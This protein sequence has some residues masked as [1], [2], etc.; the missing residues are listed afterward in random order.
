[1]ATTC[2]LAPPARR[3]PV[4]S[5]ATRQPGARPAST[6][7]FRHQRSRA[8]RLRSVP[9]LS[10]RFALALG[11]L[12]AGTVTSCG[13]SPHANSSGPITARRVSHGLRLTLMLPK[14]SYPRNALIGATVKVQNVSHHMISAPGTSC[15]QTE[16]F[17]EDI[18][19]HGRILYPDG[20]SW[21]NLI[22]PCGAATEDTFMGPGF[23]RSLGPV[24][25]IARSSTLRAV[26]DIRESG[27]SQTSNTPAFSP[28]IRLH[29]GP[30]SAPKIALR[31]QAR[32]AAHL[33]PGFSTTAP[34]VFLSLGHCYPGSA[35]Y[36][37]LGTYWGPA[38]GR[39]IMPECNHPSS[40]RA[41]A[42]W[43]G[44][45]VAFIHYVRAGSR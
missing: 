19:P 22:P 6:R 24:Y 8:H 4:A 16:P 17:V 3:S 29:L 34:P 36:D 28:L 9:L 32:V 14:R 23:K 26:M 42:G 21:L 2:S 18:G 44:H 20:V 43:P 41:I 10:T 38:S 31:A 1:M 11:M 5:V 45:S 25:V 13:S 40:W 37:Y 33:D 12:A 39:T 7:L 30:Y 35:P 15:T 27:V